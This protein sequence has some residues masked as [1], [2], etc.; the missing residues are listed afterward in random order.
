MEIDKIRELKE[1]VALG[2]DKYPSVCCFTFY[3][4][5]EKFLFFF[6]FFLSFFSFFFFKKLIHKN[7]K[8]SLTSLSLTGDCSLMSVGFSDSLIRLY[9]IQGKNLKK[10]KE[11]TKLEEPLDCKN[12]NKKE[13]QK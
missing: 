10:L 8:I 1:K 4:T 11:G 2:R 5:N 7:Q 6:F 3:N 9:N 13:K 12:K